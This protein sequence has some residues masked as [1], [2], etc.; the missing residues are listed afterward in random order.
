[1]TI[2]TNQFSYTPERRLVQL[3]L[4]LVHRIRRFGR[5][6]VRGL[7]GTASSFIVHLNLDLNEEQGSLRP[8]AVCREPRWTGGLSGFLPIARVVA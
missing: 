6:S 4:S 2:S 1:M 3:P 8:A 5:G 7:V